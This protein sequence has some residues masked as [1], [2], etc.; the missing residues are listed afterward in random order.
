MG[1]DGKQR[2][3]QWAELRRRRDEED[4]RERVTVIT[5]FDAGDPRKN[6]PNLSPERSLAR[7]PKHP[8][9][10]LDFLPPPTMNLNICEPCL[11]MFSFT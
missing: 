6:T 11:K 3:E 7:T 5:E 9:N 8:K 2:A 4:R 1:A 10:L